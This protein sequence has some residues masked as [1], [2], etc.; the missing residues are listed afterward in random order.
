MFEHLNREALASGEHVFKEGDMGDCAYIIEE[1][2]VQIYVQGEDGERLINVIGK[3]ELLGEVALID[4]QPR[5]ASARALQKTVLVIVQ[6]KLMD[7]LLEQTNPIVRHL[8]LVVLERFRVT[9][10][11][12]QNPGMT[13][14][15]D[16]EGQSNVT[17][18]R[19]SIRGEATQKLTLARDISR[20]L[21]NSE[22]ELYY[23]PICELSTGLVA[24]FEALIRWNHPRD[25]LISPLDFI[26]LAEQ[27]GQIREIGLWTLE[28]AC[29]DWPELRG[30]TQYHTPFVSVNLSA[31]QLTG[32]GL[33]D[34]VKTIMA[35]YGMPPTEL[36]L[37]LTETVIINNPDVA[38]ELLGKLG[39]LGSTLALDDFGTGHSGLDSLQ[40]YPIGTIKID[41][42]FIRRLRE[43]PQS[44]A[45]V[46]SSINLAHSLGMNV[47]AEGVENEEIWRTLGELGCDFG[48]GWHFGRPEE[49]K[50][51]RRA[52][53]R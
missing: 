10:H 31:S 48:Q 53:R 32:V 34:D 51:G 37:E 50:V 11:Q 18:R 3:G 14:R 47:V 24:G 17:A 41:I 9:R 25:G 45:I 33:I 15:E 7:G 27:T 52:G 16:R 39:E 40:R 43:S 22:F 36:K 12:E 1:G 38:L 8:L 5:T 29:M 42:A 4:R 2:S 46:R 28:R 20:A 19:D 13:R 6:R 30:R 44:I 21:A 23:Q 35:L 26:W 49:L